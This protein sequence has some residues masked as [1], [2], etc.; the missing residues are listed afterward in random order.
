MTNFNIYLVGCLLNIILFLIQKKECDKL[1]ENADVNLLDTNTLKCTIYS[2]VILGS[3][4][5][6]WYCVYLSFKNLLTKNKK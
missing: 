4:I 6:F 1:I 2:V 5:V 3:W